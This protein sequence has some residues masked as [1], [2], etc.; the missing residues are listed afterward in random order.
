MVDQRFCSLA[1]KLV[2]HTKP[3]DLASLLAQIR[4]QASDRGLRVA[5]IVSAS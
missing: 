4:V 1:K 3:L 5:M 2:L